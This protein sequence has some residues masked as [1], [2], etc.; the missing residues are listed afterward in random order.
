MIQ[1]KTLIFIPCLVDQVYPEIG[2]AMA[3]IL[4]HLGYKIVYNSAQTCCGQPAFNAGFRDEAKK[5]ATRFIQVFSGADYIVGPSGSCT[6]MVKNYYPILFKNDPYE[7]S[8]V[9]QNILNFTILDQEKQINK[10]SELIKAGW[11]FIIL[12]QLQRTPY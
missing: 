5:I 8:L 3:K 4:E 9:G 11:D 12:S 6:A 7:D 2:F 10:I 1:Q